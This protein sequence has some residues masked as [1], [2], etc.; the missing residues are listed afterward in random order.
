MTALSLRLPLLRVREGWALVAAAWIV[1][2]VLTLAA[3][4]VLRALGPLG[5]LGRRFYRT[6]LGLLSTWDGVWYRRIVD[7]GYVFVPGRQ[8]DVAFFPGYPLVV[9]AL[10]ATGLGFSVVGPLA[11]NVLLLVALVAFY[12]LSCRMFDRDFAG[13]A[14]VF[15]ALAP[16]GFVYSMSYPSS[17]LFACVALACLAALADAWGLAAVFAAF[18]GLTRPEA[19]VVV[20]PLAFL[21]WSR[22][23]WLGPRRFGC[24]LAAAAAAPV[25]IASYPAY[26]KWAVGDGHAWSTAEVAWGRSFRLD[27]PWLALRKLPH[28]LAEHPGYAGDLMLLAAYAVLLVAARR[29]GTSWP[30]IAGGLL[31]LVVPL[32]SGTIESEGR[33]GL[34]ALP[35]YWGLAASTRSPRAGGA[36]R[37][38]SGALLVAGVLTLPF[39]WP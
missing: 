7:Y 31:V 32:F 26:L 15:A 39:I 4:A 9:K 25:A 8:S 16:A 18:A 22:R 38:V 27:G 34:V 14:A 23:K 6:P 12:E 2:R 33:F 36:A 20:V 13:R 11:S 19:I 35:V 10:T 29:A 21:A 17:L 1:S 28:A 30:W 3:F 24:A 37:L 5:Y